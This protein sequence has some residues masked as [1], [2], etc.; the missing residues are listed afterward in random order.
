MVRI[1]EIKNIETDQVII[2]NVPL[3]IIS[4]VSDNILWIIFICI[5]VLIYYKYKN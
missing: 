1:E 2:K 5:I 4:F 3:D